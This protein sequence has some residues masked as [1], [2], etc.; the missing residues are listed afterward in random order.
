MRWGRLKLAF[1]TILVAVPARLFLLA[2]EDRLEAARRRVPLGAD[3]DAVAASVGMPADGV[4]GLVGRTGEL[5]R[6]VLFWL[7]GDDQ[8][9][10]EF[11]EDGAAVGVQIGRWGDPTLWELVWS[12]LWWR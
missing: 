8:V 1:L 12:Q 6:R 5:S 3:E 2:P 11:D 10:V 9:L 7:C 4:V